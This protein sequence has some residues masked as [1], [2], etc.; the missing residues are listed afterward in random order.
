MELNVNTSRDNPNSVISHVNFLFGH[1]SKLICLEN[2]ANE[3]VVGSPR[4][5]QLHPSLSPDP[6]QERVVGQGAHNVG[7]Q[8]LPSVPYQWQQIRPINWCIRKCSYT[9]NGIQRGGI[10]KKLNLG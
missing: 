8:P 5:C 7:I 4:A 9:I 2:S 1:Q 10:F 3:I 6:S